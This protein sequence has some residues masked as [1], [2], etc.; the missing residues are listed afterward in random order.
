[1][2]TRTG[3]V[4]ISFESFLHLLCTDRYKGP[5]S[6]FDSP[7]KQQPPAL[8]E[9]NSKPFLFSQTPTTKPAT[10]FPSSSFTTP[11]KLEPDVDLSSGA[12]TSPENVGG[13]VTPEPLP[14]KPAKRNSLFNMYGR[15]APS[16][17]R[18]EIPKSKDFS[19]VLVRRV[20]KRRK[21]D[22]DIDRQRHRPN[23][24]SDQETD[25]EDPPQKSSKP[26]QKQEERS[27][28][29]YRDI[30]VFSTLFTF[31]EAHPH[32]PR[33]LSFYTQLAFNTAIIVLGLYL[34]IAFVFTIW[35]DI[36]KESEKAS[37]DILAEMTICAKNFVEN[38]CGGEDGKRLPALET[39]CDNWERCMNQDPQGVGRAKLSAH[40]IAEIVNSF[41]EP[42]SYK[43]M[44]S[45]RGRNVS[46]EEALNFL[47]DLRPDYTHFLFRC[48]QLDLFTLPQQVE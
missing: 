18:G 6:I 23:D 38:R 30:P 47:I 4:S 15:F 32:A 9:P 22:R 46:W 36:N 2:R 3:S 45:L 17:G 16:P 8:R 19:N 1:M 29:T 37:A 34:L 40:A 13:E 14:T 24:D 12:E 44:V 25:A 20:H 35:S 26:R 11:R 28:P 7:T 21:R 5:Y 33:I 48:K 42:I 27:Y 31:L 41:I 43:T 39:V 10:T